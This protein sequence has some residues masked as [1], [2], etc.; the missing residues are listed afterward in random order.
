MIICWLL[1]GLERSRNF[2]ERALPVIA[3]QWMYTVNNGNFIQPI[4]AQVFTLL[5]QSD[6]RNPFG[7][8]CTEAWQESLCSERLPFLLCSDIRFRRH[9][10]TRW[11]PKKLA[12]IP[13]TDAAVPDYLTNNKKDLCSSLKDGAL[14]SLLV[15]LKFGALAL[16]VR[17]DLSVISLIFVVNGA[18]LQ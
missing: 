4:K 12:E 14:W 5:D 3:C 6:F 10:S 16:L 11:S 1:I 17:S 18:L 7:V 13:P 15:S 8:K 2:P 9:I